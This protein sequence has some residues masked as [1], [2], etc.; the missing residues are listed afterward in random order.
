MT[1][2]S[3]AS[4][5]TV[6][7]GGVAAENSGQIYKCNSKVA[8][9]VSVSMAA[10]VAEGSF[11]YIG[12]IA[13][14]NPEGGIISGA[15]H[16]GK[17]TINVGETDNAPTVYQGGVCGV[18]NGIISGCTFACFDESINQVGFGAGISS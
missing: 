9:G 3:V 11:V 13:G 7:A 14:E 10:N 18:N 2:G 4:I 6:R 8:I 5:V 16:T 12:G 15:N 17:M 1:L